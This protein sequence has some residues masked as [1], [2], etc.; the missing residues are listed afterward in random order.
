MS[1]QKLMER[2]GV[3]RVEKIQRYRLTTTTG[4]THLIDFIPVSGM[5]GF[6]HRVALDG[7]L[8]STYL[9]A[10]LNPSSQYNAVD[11]L[12]ILRK[13]GCVKRSYVRLARLGARSDMVV[14]FKVLAE[15]PNTI[16]LSWG[17]GA[18]PN[19]LLH[20]MTDGTLQADGE[21]YVEVPL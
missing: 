9:S 13:K 20:K 10:Q 17:A 8:T 12:D 19:M 21:V 3:T 16:T 7:E 2:T 14:L 11:M 5:P 6:S 4:E 15:T 1:L 18:G